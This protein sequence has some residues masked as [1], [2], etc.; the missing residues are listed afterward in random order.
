MSFRKLLLIKL[1]FVLAL[2]FGLFRLDRLNQIPISIHNFSTYNLAEIYALG[3]VMSAL[4]YPIYPEVAEEHL[5]LYFREKKNKKSCFF[6]E[7]EI[8]SQEI[9]N[10]EK[11]KVITWNTSTYMIGHPEARFS[12]ALNGA[13]L[14]I[15]NDI[16]SV[17]VPIRYPKKSLVK[18][19]PFIEVEEGLFWVLQE[20]GWYHPG[21]FIW[22]CENKI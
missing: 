4:A 17:E 15:K 8:L 5:S 20:K 13:T 19:L 1:C 10:Y 16:I 7:S 21:T 22:E 18:L 9:A 3:I 11:P 2:G 14:K 6:M 12:L